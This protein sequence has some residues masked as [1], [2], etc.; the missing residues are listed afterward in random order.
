MTNLKYK[1]FNDTSENYDAYVVIS[2]KKPIC[3]NG[4]FDS[5]TLT[6]SDEE[7]EQSETTTEQTF[8]FDLKPE[9][10]YTVGVSVKN[11]QGY[12]KEV[13]LTFTSPPGS[14][15]LII[16]QCF[17]LVYIYNCK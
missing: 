15:Y 1:I 6:L 17:K 13:D 11:Q 10:N 2:Y 7:S 12:Q 16:Q 14:K 9:V 5:F 3:I 8:K 4:D